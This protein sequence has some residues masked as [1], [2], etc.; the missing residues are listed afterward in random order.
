MNAG[1]AHWSTVYQ[2][3][4]ADQVSWHQTQPTLSLELIQATQAAVSAPIIDMGAGAS[5][6]VDHLLARGYTTITLLD[7]AAEALQV[8]QDRLGA[9]AAALTWITGDATT[10]DLPAA[11]YAVWHDRAVFHFLTDPLA[12]ARY[13]EQLNHALQ[14][15]GHVIIATFA[16]DGPEMCSGLP[17]ARY[18]VAGLQAVLG[19]AFT[20]I[21]SHTET[22][23]TP[24]GSEQN[25]IYCHFRRSSS[26]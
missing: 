15:N 17:V 2:T 3:K 13:I 18:D 26:S 11:H 9:A 5:T 25:F 8:A 4:A 7:L 12:R 16:L 21:S 14:A 22:H 10:A 6:L 19:A 1:Q 23:L 20:L 24:W